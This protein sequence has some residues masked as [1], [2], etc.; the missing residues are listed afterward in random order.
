MARVRRRGDEARVEG[1]AI[2]GKLADVGLDEAM[3]C[4]HRCDVCSI[5]IRDGSI[6]TPSTHRRRER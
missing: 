4:A 1:R 5:A 6:T 3:A 2:Q